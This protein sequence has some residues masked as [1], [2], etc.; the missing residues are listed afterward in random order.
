MQTP[1]EIARTTSTEAQTHGGGAVIDGAAPTALV[2]TIVV[3]YNNERQIADCLT[4]LSA[5]PAAARHIIVIDNEIGR[6]SCRERV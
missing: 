6:A 2:S 1:T 5:D 3:T 4:A